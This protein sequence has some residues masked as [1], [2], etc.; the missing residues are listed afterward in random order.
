MGTAV[1]VDLGG[2]A[3]SKGIQIE[4]EGTRENTSLWATRASIKVAFGS[5]SI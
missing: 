4:V 5:G 1:G 2:G 3:I